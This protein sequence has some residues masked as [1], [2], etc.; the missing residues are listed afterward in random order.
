MRI[1][2][3]R[4]LDVKLRAVRR[5]DQEVRANP[6]MLGIARADRERMLGALDRGCREARA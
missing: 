5:R 1:T 2:G 3:R 4:P 6:H